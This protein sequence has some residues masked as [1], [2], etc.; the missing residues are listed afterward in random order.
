MGGWPSALSSNHADQPPPFTPI[1]YR[2][3]R[4]YLNSYCFYIREC[5]MWR[6][7]QPLT[8]TVRQNWV[9]QW[10]GGAVSTPSN[11]SMAIP[12]AMA[13]LNSSFPLVDDS[14]FRLLPLSEYYHCTALHRTSKMTQISDP[15][16]AAELPAIVESL[17]L[18][19]TAATS[20]TTTTTTTLTTTKGPQFET[21]QL[22][23][24]QVPDPTTKSRAPPIYA[25]TSFLFERYVAFSTTTTTRRRRRRRS[26]LKLLMLLYSCYYSDHVW[27]GGAVLNTGPICSA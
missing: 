6:A 5:K 26:H 16:S 14:S 17:K 2:I 27:G 23:G 3:N 8:V 18:S 9:A 4:C 11:P 22:H 24:G 13:S 12:R 25:S 20:A 10:H 7:C 19:A 1:F 21:V 15:F